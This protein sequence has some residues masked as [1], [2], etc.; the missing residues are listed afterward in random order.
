MTRTPRI[1]LAQIRTTKGNYGANLARLG[2]VFAQIAQ[3]ESIDLLITPEL[4]LIH[5]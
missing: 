4:S 2:S 3:L 1:A 5:I